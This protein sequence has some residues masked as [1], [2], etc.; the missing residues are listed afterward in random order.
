MPVQRRIGFSTE[1]FIFQS[2]SDFVRQQPNFLEKP[3]L[4]PCQTVLRRTL[5]KHE[6]AL[7]TTIPVRHTRKGKYYKGLRFLSDEFFGVSVII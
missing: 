4:Q 6:T 2:I 5:G 1:R 7:M 3:R